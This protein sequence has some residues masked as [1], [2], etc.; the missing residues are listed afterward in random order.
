[1]LIKIVLLVVALIILPAIYLGLYWK[2]VLVG[3]RLL[4]IAYFIS[5]LV[6]GYPVIRYAIGM[7]EIENSFPEECRRTLDLI[8]KKNNY[9]YS[10]YQKRLLGTVFGI[11]PN[12]YFS[13]TIAIC[14]YSLGNYEYSI[15][16]LR[17]LLSSDELKWSRKFDTEKYHDLLEKAETKR[18]VDKSGY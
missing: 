8:N 4:F 15:D 1:M 3:V 17:T 9:V 12:V 10:E 18:S 6:L 11:T 2:R 7:S 16:A 5:L 14:E 13:S